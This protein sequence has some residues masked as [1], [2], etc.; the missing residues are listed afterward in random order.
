MQANHPFIAQR[1]HL[2]SARALLGLN[3]DGRYAAAFYPG[4]VLHILKALHSGGLL[5]TSPEEALGFLKAPRHQRQ[6]H[7]GY[8][9]NA[10]PEHLQGL[11]GLQTEERRGISYYE[12]AAV[13]ELAELGDTDCAPAGAKAWSIKAEEVAEACYAED[14]PEKLELELALAEKQAIQALEM[15][16]KEIEYTSA[17]IVR[18]NWNGLSEASKKDWRIKAGV[19]R[20][21]SIRIRTARN[22]AVFKH[23]DELP[24][25]VVGLIAAG[26]VAE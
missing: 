21:P 2:H 22:K 3:D 9:R 6:L 25:D 4:G 16:R 18:T 23:M 20:K 12:R 13:A 19:L 15:R 10:K 26:V 24:D 8:H 1:R 17:H 11:P 14:E 5:A 7:G